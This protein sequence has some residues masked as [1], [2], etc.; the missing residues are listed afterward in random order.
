MLLKCLYKVCVVCS[1]RKF[2]Y[3]RLLLRYDFIPRRRLGCVCMCSTLLCILFWRMP[4]NP[5]LLVLSL[6][7]RYTSQ[8]TLRNPWIHCVGNPQFFRGIGEDIR[9]I[10]KGVS[11]E[12]SKGSAESSKDVRRIVKGCPQ[13]CRRASAYSQPSKAS[14]E[15]Y[16]SPRIVEG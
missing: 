13:I 9:G 15:S 7:L 3:A 1:H 8:E 2:G 10:V 11:T 6:M 14:A 5:D 16:C 12:S 4:P